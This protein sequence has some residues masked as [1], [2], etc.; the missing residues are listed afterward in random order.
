MSRPPRPRPRSL[1]DLPTTTQYP[2]DGPPRPAPQ[3]AAVEAEDRK[4]QTLIE[5]KI[6]VALSASNRPMSPSELL[7]LYVGKHNRVG[8]IRAACERLVAEGRV[9]ATDTPSSFRPGGV[10][11]HYMIAPKPHPNDELLAKARNRT[12]GPAEPTPRPRRRQERGS[13]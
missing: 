13:T 9:I 10:V 7:F 3:P 2:L 12:V 5:T 8:P 11:R 6:L 1:D 4:R